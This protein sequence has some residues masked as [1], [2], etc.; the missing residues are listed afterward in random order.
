MLYKEGDPSAKPLLRGLFYVGDYK[1]FEPIHIYAF[2][3]F[4]NSFYELLI[5]FFEA[6]NQEFQMGKSGFCLYTNCKKKDKSKVAFRLMYIQDVIW[7]C[8]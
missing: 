3:V 4:S 8:F 1:F 5:R 2:F 6:K 7:Y